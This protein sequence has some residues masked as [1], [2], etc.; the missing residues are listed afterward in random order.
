MVEQ[1]ALDLAPHQL[2]EEIVKSAAGFTI[3]LRL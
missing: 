1:A 2:L 3:S